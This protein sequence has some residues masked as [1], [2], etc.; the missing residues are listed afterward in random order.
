MNHFFWLNVKASQ[1]WTLL[2]FAAFVCKSETKLSLVHTRQG[3]RKQDWQACGA[4]FMYF[5]F[6][7][8]RI[9]FFT[10]LSLLRSKTLL[11][12]S[13]F[14]SVV[15]MHVSSVLLIHVL[16]A[17]YFFFFSSCLYYL[18]SNQTFRSSVLQCIQPMRNCKT[19]EKHLEF[20]KALNPATPWKDK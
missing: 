15:N 8:L 3:R 13:D 14:L 7:T 16:Y 19:I 5:N 1:A 10:S 17:T 12:S 2:H 11:N 4:V 9:V 18:W 6:T 20:L